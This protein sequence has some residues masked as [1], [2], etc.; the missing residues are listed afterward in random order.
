[1]L[2]DVAI[3]QKDEENNRFRLQSYINLA[4][5]DK[6]YDFKLVQMGPLT[7]FDIWSPKALN[8]FEKCIPE[9]IDRFDHHRFLVG[10]IAPDSIVLMPSNKRWEERRKAILKT[11]GI[12]FA[13]KFIPMMINIVDDWIKD[14]EIGCDINISYELNKI[15]FRIIT[16]ILFGKDIDKMDKCWYISPVDG[17]KH[18]LNFEECYFKYSKDEFESHFSPVGK[19]LSPLANMRLI[20]PFKS[21]AKNKKSIDD[22]LRSFL[23]RSE[24]DQSVYRQILNNFDFDKSEVFA[25][26]LML[27]F[28]GFDTT[29]HGIGSTLYF[30]KKFPET[31]KKLLDSLDKDGISKI[32]P[33]EDSS[34]LKD[35]FENWDYLNYTTKEGLRID[36]PALAGL[37]QYFIYDII[38]I[39]SILKLK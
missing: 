35:K 11:I 7:L 8:E 5:S 39:F 23:D 18:T 33:N 28:A 3:F 4:L 16:K 30:L 24:D 22:A 32:N 12:N 36:P 13:S 34:K 17:S 10:N 37:L 29:S 25:D 21:N 9:K 6:K 14:L 31:L 26:V 38:L 1:M 27:L 2:G 19:I 15:T 20:E